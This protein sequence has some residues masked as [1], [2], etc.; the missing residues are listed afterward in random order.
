MP[1]TARLV[2]RE[3]GLPKP[4]NSTLITADTNIALGTGYLRM[5][6][7]DLHQEEVLATAAYNAGPHRVTRWLEG[8]TLPVDLWVEMI[9]FKET[10]TYV[11]RV[12]AYAIIYDGRL[13]NPTRRLS[14]RMRST[15]PGA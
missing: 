9:P 10:R 12:L 5:M 3:K 15:R 7:D 13:G 1:A 14:E 6:L 2:A 8:S 11:Q 4:S